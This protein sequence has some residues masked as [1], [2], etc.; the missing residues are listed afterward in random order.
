MEQITTMKK[1]AMRH[2][3]LLHDI[4]MKSGHTPTNDELTDYCEH[5]AHVCTWINGI[6]SILTERR[7]DES[8]LEN[9]G[10]IS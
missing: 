10:Y 6:I 7:R 9:G 5:Y 1:C 4:N 8:E 3:L 2:K